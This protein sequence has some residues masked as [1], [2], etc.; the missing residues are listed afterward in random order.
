MIPL[1]RVKVCS[2]PECREVLPA[3]LAQPAVAGF[4][5][6]RRNGAVIGFQ[7]YCKPCST[8][9]RREWK[10]AN[11][12]VVNAKRRAWHAMK[13]ATDSGYRERHNAASRASNARWL[14]KPGG[15]E[16]ARLAAREY[17]RRKRQADR[18]GVNEQARMDYALRMERRGRPAKYHGTVIDGTRPEL[19]AG[20]FR[21]WLAAYRRARGLGSA[22]ELAQEL[23]LVERRVR[24]QL[25]GGQASVSVD[26]VS[27][28]LTEARVVVDVGGRTV[29]TLD[30]LYTGEP[31]REKRQKR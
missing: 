31:L 20:P 12:E 9:R 11:R 13:M 10:D 14:A 1:D 25:A 18:D 19:P 7:S 16:R 22:A 4:Y 15:V 26:V 28:A 3:D 5:A 27:R 21:E 17:H 29:V 6:K 24:S 8:R 30:D 23:G 2:N